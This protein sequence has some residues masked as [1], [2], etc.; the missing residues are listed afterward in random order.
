MGRK[1]RTIE[2]PCCYHITHRC[3]ERRFL[4]KRE[5]DRSNYVR[6]L[7]QMVKRYEVDVLNYTVTKNH[8]HLLL[9]AKQAKDI[10]AGL[11]FL[12]G[13]TAGDYNRRVKREGAFWRG[14][15]HATLIENGPHLGRCVFYIDLNMLRAGVVS[16]PAEWPAGGHHE[17]IGTRQRYR[18][19][20][21]PR[22]IRCMGHDPGI[23]GSLKRFREWYAGTLAEKLAEAY[24]VR[25]P[26]WSE[27]AAIGSKEFVTNLVGPLQGHRA[28]TH[29]PFGEVRCRT[30]KH[31]AAECGQRE[32]A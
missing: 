17:L 4:F 10:S 14:R 2:Q 16:H 5:L 29:H 22:L 19:I 12:Q 23:G 15:Y 1:R 24:H 21:I 3:Q 9:F 13:T 25:E 6:R 8:I 32:V 26:F 7:R 30:H 20:N 31:H 11:H 27:A 28:D 18:L